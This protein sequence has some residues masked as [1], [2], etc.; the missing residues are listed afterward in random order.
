[1][2]RTA[3]T[4]GSVR[5]KLVVY[6]GRIPDYSEKSKERLA[7]VVEVFDPYCELWEQHAVMG[8]TPAVG[9]YTA[10]GASV[11][12][13][14][15]MFGGFDGITWFNSLHRLKHAINT[16]YW[17][18]LSPDSTEA[19]RPMRKSGAGMVVF[20]DTLVLLGGYGIPHSPQPGT[21]FVTNTRFRDGRGLTNEFHLYHLKEGM[22]VQTGTNIHALFQ[23]AF[24]ILFTVLLITL[25]LCVTVY[26]HRCLELP[27][28]HWRE[29]SS[30]CWLLLHL[31]R[32]KEGSNVCRILC[33][34]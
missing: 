6:G 25:S 33:A 23:S 2:L 9:V 21:T 16:Y 8:Q 34:S 13:D 5:E 31:D 17:K 11:N 29:T 15:Y 27:C 28:D 12:N 24:C 3:H 19:G 7:S 18:E 32:Q 4:S 14:L 20:S 10:A 1:M 30:M 26:I 22:P